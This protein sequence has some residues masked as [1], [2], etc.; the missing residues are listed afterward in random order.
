MAHVSGARAAIAVRRERVSLSVSAANLLAEDAMG[1]AAL[2]RTGAVSAEALAEAAI[3]RIE[4]DARTINAFADRARLP[5]RGPAKGLFAGVPFAIKNLNTF[6]EGCTASFGSAR[7][8][9]RV[10]A[11]DSAIVGRYRAAGFVILGTTNSPELSLSLSTESALS[12]VTRHPCDPFG[13]YGVGGSSG[14]A[15]AAVAAGFVPAAHATDSA[16]S[17]RAPAAHTGLIGLK[18]TRGLT[19][20]EP[21]LAADP[22]T[23]T[24]AHAV[25]R[26]VRDSAALLEVAA[27][28]SGLLDA[29]G[30]SLSGRTVALVDP[31]RSGVAFSP[32]SCA[33]AEACAA[34]LSRLGLRVVGVPTPFRLSDLWP[35][36]TRII[37]RRTFAAVGDDPAGLEP[38]TAALAAL[39]AAD[40]GSDPAPW[41][42]A[43][44][45]PLIALA[46]AHDF[47]LTPTLSVD[48]VPLGSLPMDASPAMHVANL[49]TMGGFSSAYNVTGLPA[50]SLPFGALPGG[51][52]VGAMVGAAAGRDA[53]LLSLAA[54]LEAD[55]AFIG[56]AH[57]RLIGHSP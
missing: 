4:A 45:A 44:A 14:G 22:L 51:V 48:A 53:A 46:A 31:A 28:R 5:A 24:T 27:A 39:G 29:L 10:A 47:V 30:G 49:L 57:R 56:D 40:H 33:A 35:T 42:S 17:I 9:D 21:S 18:P 50:I 16:G 1:L 11:A 15:A 23:L 19:P 43:I 37:A 7:F 41:A 32:A 8:A 54:A 38:V 6:V 2:V 13:R 52:S 36:L 3:A 12:G 26:T 25:T 55:G 20:L 34:A